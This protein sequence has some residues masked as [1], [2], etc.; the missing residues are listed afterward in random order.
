MWIPADNDIP[1]KFINNLISFRLQADMVTLYIVNRDVRGFSRNLMS[2][3]YNFIY[4]ISFKIYLLNITSI[5]IY[6][7]K[8]LKSIDLKSTRFG[9]TSEI[10]TKMY[11]N[12]SFVIQKPLYVTNGIAGST[13]F[14]LIN[15]C[16]LLK[17]FIECLHYSYI[18]RKKISITQLIDP[19]GPN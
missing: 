16:E 1:H 2:S 10:N 14:S 12:S 13:A 7:T 11:L 17:S 9:I 5:G 6:N 18:R 4:M 8:L 15:I 3:F 19:D